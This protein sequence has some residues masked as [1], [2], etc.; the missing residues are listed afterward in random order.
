VR[1]IQ[2]PM[3]PW[4]AYLPGLRVLART[5]GAPGEGDDVPVSPAAVLAL[6]GQLMAPQERERCRRVLAA[7]TPRQSEVLRAFAGGGTPQDVAESLY[8]TLKTVDSHKTAILA[9]CRLAWAMPADHWLD[10]HFLRERFGWFFE[11]RGTPAA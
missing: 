2:V 4:G 9:E 3:L 1:L 8:I 5:P 11:S 10:Y 7:L 6:H